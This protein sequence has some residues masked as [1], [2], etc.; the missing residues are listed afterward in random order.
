[1][2]Q[3]CKDIR[4][5]ELPLTAIDSHGQFLHVVVNASWTRKAVSPTI[6]LVVLPRNSGIARLAI[7]RAAVST[8]TAQA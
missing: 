6:R 3:W 8:H 2:R 7:Q 1:M 4:P 5:R